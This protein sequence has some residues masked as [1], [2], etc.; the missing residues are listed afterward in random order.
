LFLFLT[1]LKAPSIKLGPQSMAKAI[2]FAFHLLLLVPKLGGQ[3]KI[4]CS[5]FMHGDLSRA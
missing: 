3:T 1:M 4:N 5:N 2:F